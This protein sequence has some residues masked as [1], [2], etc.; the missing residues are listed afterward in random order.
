LGDVMP[1]FESETINGSPVISGG[2]DGHA[3]VVSFVSSECKACERTL[4]AAQT[5][6][7][8]QHDLIVVSVFEEE[9]AAK[10]RPFA[11]R[12][13]LHFPV[14]IDRDGAIAKSFK[15]AQ[16]PSTF[17]IDPRGRVSW[18]AGSELT[19]DGLDRAISAVD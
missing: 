6:Y 17:V 19:E 3:V 1:A 15:V 2:Y 4:T 5:M 14:V 16:R 10:A 18:I 8:A 13:G 11:E 9:D 7:G 12:L